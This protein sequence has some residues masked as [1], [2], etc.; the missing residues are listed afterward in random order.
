MGSCSP[1]GE[2]RAARNGD[3]IK[4]RWFS[5]G[6]GR[7]KNQPWEKKKPVQLLMRWKDWNGGDHG[8][9]NTGP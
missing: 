6:E 2:R 4:T 8:L 5:E 9:T 1:S 7:W 3:L